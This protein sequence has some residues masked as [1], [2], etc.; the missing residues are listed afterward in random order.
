MPCPNPFSGDF[1]AVTTPVKDVWLAEG[2]VEN[3]LG[4]S[5]RPQ[6]ILRK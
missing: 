4:I 6:D 5:V 2:I 1:Q 3:L